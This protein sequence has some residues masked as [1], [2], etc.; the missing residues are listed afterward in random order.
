MKIFGLLLMIN[1]F[2]F[3]SCQVK[4]VRAKY[5]ELGS[6][7]K[8]EKSLNIE[9]N[10]IRIISNADFGTLPINRKFVNRESIYKTCFLQNSKG[11]NVFRLAYRII[12]DGKINIREIIDYREISASKTL[13]SFKPTEESKDLD[14]GFSGEWAYEIIDN[15]MTWSKEGKTISFVR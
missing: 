8:L 6:V 15:K 10:E 2:G 3:T 9:D 5:E 12:D 1:L 4:E 7:W 13:V 11:E 14:K